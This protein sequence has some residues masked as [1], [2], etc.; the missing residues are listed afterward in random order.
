M[1]IDDPPDGTIRADLTALSI[2]QALQ[3]LDG[4]G[5][6]ELADE[7]DLAKSS[8]HKHLKS[9]EFAGYLTNKD[10]EY[11]LGLKFLDHGGF[12][13][14]RSHL[15]MVARPEIREL[16]NVTGEV[17]LFT[18]KER[19]EGVFAFIRNEHYGLSNKIHQGERFLLHTNA[20]GK[21]I[22]AQLPKEDVVSLLDD[23]GLPKRTENTITSKAE[24]FDEIEQIQ[25][26]GYSTSTAERSPGVISISAAIRD[27]QYDQIGA[28]TLSY[29]QDQESNQIEEEYVEAV[30]EARNRLQLKTRYQ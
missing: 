11:A 14:N 8:V 10:G 19:Q 21:A 16:G 1:N 26:Q 27:P 6:S 30:K 13:L 12:A 23:V 29:P 22:L 18:I 3:E 20:P 5:V 4:A 7:L 9:L 28:V 24:L 17:A 2:V 25:D 15:C